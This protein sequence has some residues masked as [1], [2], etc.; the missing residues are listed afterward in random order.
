MERS[1]EASTTLSAAVGRVREI[2]LDDPVTAFCDE[3]AEEVRESRRLPA[4]LAVDVSGGASVQQE[5]EIRLGVAR[6]T[7]KGGVTLPLT[8]EPRAHHRVLPS[9]RGELEASPDRSG[10]AISLRGTYDVPL[11]PVG[12]FGDDVAGRQLAQRSLATY[13]EQIAHRLDAEVDRR[14]EI[15][16]PADSRARGGDRPA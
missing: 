2:L 16:A 6:S 9:F 5:V 4:H 7:G 8:W 11:G 1:L 10:T 14:L 15:S 13:L 3:F 12:R